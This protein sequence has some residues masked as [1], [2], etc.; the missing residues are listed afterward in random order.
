MANKTLIASAIFAAVTIGLVATGTLPQKILVHS[1]GHIT[2]P[3]DS[4]F[5]HTSTKVK[6]KAD[7]KIV[8]TYSIDYNTQ[9]RIIEIK[10][11]EGKWIRCVEDV[12]AFTGPSAAGAGLS[13]DWTPQAR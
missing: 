1:D 11:P 6:K 4:V 10:S 5:G 2:V 9:M 7:H 13:C 8:A 3:A 12:Y